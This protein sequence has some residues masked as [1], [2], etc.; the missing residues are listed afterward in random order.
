MTNWLRPVTKSRKTRF[1]IFHKSGKKY[2]I[3]SHLPK[4]K[5]NNYNT[6]K[7]NTMK[8]L[9]AW[10]DDYLSWR[11]HIRYLE[12]KIAK[13][14]GLMNK[15]K[16]FLGKESLLALNYSYIH[17]YLNYAN[18]V[19]RSAYLTNLKKLC[20]QQIPAIRIVHNKTKFEHAK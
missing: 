12:N 5:V 10:L 2:S 7:L 11:E 15:A 18:L 6:E 1:S 17:S 9:S 19:W 13:N 3:P 20:S 14:I 4:L 16:S 8:F